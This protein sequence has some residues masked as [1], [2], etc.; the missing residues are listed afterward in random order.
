MLQ[1]SDIDSPQVELYKLALE[2]GAPSCIWDFVI[3]VSACILGGRDH[4]STY[5]GAR[6]LIIVM[7]CQHCMHPAVQS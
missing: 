3:T 5:T 4:F 2:R 7:L 1:G 6:L